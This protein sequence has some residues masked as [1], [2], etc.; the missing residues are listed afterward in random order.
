MATK[1]LAYLDPG[2][3]A[4]V[5]QMLVGALAA[6]AVSVKLFWR[7]ILHVLRPRRKSDLEP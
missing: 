2:S 1:E 7:R 3:A 6:A 5:I 4:M